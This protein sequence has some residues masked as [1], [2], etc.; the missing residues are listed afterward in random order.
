MSQGP[1]RRTRGF[2]SC[3]AQPKRCAP[4]RRHATRLRLLNGC[5]VSG[6]TAGSLRMRNS[7]GSSPQATA[8]SSIADSSANNPGHSPDGAQ[9]ASASFDGT[10][11]LW[12]MESFGCLQTFSGHTDRNQVLRVAWSPDGRTLAS[13]GFDKTIWLW[14][15]TEGRSQ[16]ALHGHIAVIYA[17]A[18]TS[19]SRTLLS[20]SDDGTI[21]VWNVDSAFA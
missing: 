11:K 12:D 7:I 15:V 17:I 10:I 3:G 9:L 8:S 16:A 4:C 20:G 1:S 13:S 2:G 21:R 19:D 14:D 6:S 5:P 18:F